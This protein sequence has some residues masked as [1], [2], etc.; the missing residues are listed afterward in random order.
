MAYDPWFDIDLEGYKRFND[1]RLLNPNLKTILAVG[2]WNEG[3]EKYSFM[4]ADPELRAG[5]VQSCKEFVLLY[6]FDGLDLD[7]EYPSMRGGSDED[8]L[9]YAALV[10]EMR[11]AFDD[12]DLLLTTAV[13]PNKFTIEDSYDIQALLESMDFLNVMTYD[14]HGAW[15]NFTHHNAPLYGHPMDE[16]NF[17]YF[18][19]EATVDFWLGLG[20]HKEFIN[21][22]MP[23]YGRGFTVY[24]PSEGT[25][26][27]S[28]SFAP[29]DAGPYTR[30]PGTL[31]YNEICE[32]Q[33]DLGDDFQRVWVESIKAPYVVYKE[34]QWMSYDDLE[35][36]KYKL[37]FLEE[38]QLGGGMVWSIET[39]DFRGKCSGSGD[40]NPLIRYAS[41]RL[42]VP[43]PPT[44][45]PHPTEAAWCPSEGFHPSAPCSGDYVYCQ[46]G[47]NGE[48]II[49]EFKCPEG[50]IFN[51]EN[52]ACDYE[53][54]VPGMKVLWMLVAACLAAGV[55]GQRRPIPR[56]PSYEKICQHLQDPEFVQK[57][58]QCANGS[59]QACNPVSQFLRASIPA[60]MGRSRCSFC[61][62]DDLHKT[63]FIMAEMQRL[64]PRQYRD[65]ILK[66]GTG[67]TR[68]RRQATAPLTCQQVL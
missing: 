21:M 31:G 48:W 29:S 33:D 6:D 25:D 24:D 57:Q 8:R 18:N 23:L 64:Y 19:V 7:W 11:I 28:D 14:Y 20:V 44:T 42:G 49:T 39:D 67:N 55:G 12:T 41:S 13:S 22:G 50:L 3:S 65:L 34:D 37:D 66:Y 46:L 52:A 27:Y 5:F 60:A 61:S 68:L 36:F 10:R 56:L 53:D 9:N 40:K 54:Q 45:T 1:L 58:V 4:A 2:G 38:R 47:P 51:P 43:T 30:I 16:G 15:E 32:M 59:R 35:S 26:I 17:T 63:K 62:A